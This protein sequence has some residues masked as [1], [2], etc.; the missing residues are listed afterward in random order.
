MNEANLERKIDAL[1][2]EWRDAGTRNPVLARFR[3]MTEAEACAI[4]EGDAR[5]E[6]FLR[7]QKHDCH[8]YPHGFVSTPRA[9]KE[10]MK[11]DHIKAGR[12][13]IGC[14]MWVDPNPMYS[15]PG[16]SPSYTLQQERRDA[17]AEQVDRGGPASLGRFSQ[18]D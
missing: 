11:A 5:A 9:V 6:A 18:A 10:Q 7:E 3:H 8:C 1:I 15:R 17:E 14:P 16:D 2:D 4:N 12:H 13:S